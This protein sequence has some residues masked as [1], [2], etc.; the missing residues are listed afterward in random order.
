[1]FGHEPSVAN[2][3]WPEY[4]VAKTIDATIEVVVQVNGKL[5][6]RLQM[7]Q[8]A[9]KEEMLNEAKNDE[10]IKTWIEGKE[11]VKEI[12]VPNKLVNIVVK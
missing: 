11:I 2:E 8:G 10:K 1:M 12:V 5:R 7:P 4:D 9:S 3:E 6:A